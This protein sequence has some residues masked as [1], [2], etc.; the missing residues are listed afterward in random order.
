MYIFKKKKK[1]YMC[2]GFNVIIKSHMVK[3]CHNLYYLYSIP[4]CT[5]LLLIIKIDNHIYF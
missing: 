4:A 2:N 5:T 3:L 1:N